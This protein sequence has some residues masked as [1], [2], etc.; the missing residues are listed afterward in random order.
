MLT[1]LQK[2]LR[3][4]PESSSDKNQK[5]KNF[6]FYENRFQVG[7]IFFESR[8]H[9]AAQAD[10]QSG[11]CSYIDPLSFIFSSKTGLWGSKHNFL[12][13]VFDLNPSSSWKSTFSFGA[14]LDLFLEEQIA[15]CDGFDIILKYDPKN[16]LLNNKYPKNVTFHEK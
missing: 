6:K 4:R 12:P 5:N 10:L 15:F 16:D 9:M 14:I 8:P 11:K 7:L 3:K 2:S 13:Q 1:N